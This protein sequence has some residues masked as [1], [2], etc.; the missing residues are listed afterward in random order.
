[1]YDVQNTEIKPCRPGTKSPFYANEVPVDMLAELIKLFTPQGGSVLYSF[2]VTMAAF[3]AALKIG[4]HGFGIEIIKSCQD[5]VLD[6][7]IGYLPSP[8]CTAPVISDSPDDAFDSNFSEAK[9]LLGIFD[10]ADGK[11][12]VTESNSHQSRTSSAHHNESVSQEP[13]QI[14]EARNYPEL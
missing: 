12:K 7:L 4:R 6:M 11:R 9:L 3:F 14:E 13:I 10:D 1:M 5:A 2:L 8:H